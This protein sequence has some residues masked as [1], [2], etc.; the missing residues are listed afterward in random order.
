VLLGSALIA[1]APVAAMASAA[2]APPVATAPA[3]DAI[4]LAR[5]MSPRDLLVDMEV[6]E[7]DKH[8]VSSLRSDPEMKSL[9]DVYPGLFEAM[10]KASRGLVAEAMAKSVDQIHASVARLIENSFT[11]ADIAELSNFYR[12]PIGQKT[13]QQMAAS[14]DASQVYQRAVEEKEFE[15]TEDQIDAQV[16]ANA[17]KAVQ[18]FTPEEQTQMMLFMA[19]PSFAKLA[20][21]QPQIQ[22][23]LADEFNAPDP[24]FDKEV[25]KAMG[26]AIEEHIASFEK[27]GGK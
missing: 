18:T 4:A 27:N 6:R 11:P 21:A 2:S 17:Q 24:E 10:H 25:E 15:L 20:K 3:A 12:S 13:I 23:I 19:K 16:R 1:A 8:F 7:F 9:D 14:A 22:K 5:L 26:A